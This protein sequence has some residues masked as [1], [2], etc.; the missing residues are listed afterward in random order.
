MA[1]AKAEL[2][3]AQM[4]QRRAAARAKAVRSPR[5]EW[6]TIRIELPVWESARAEAA[7]AGVS[8]AEW[9]GRKLGGRS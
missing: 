3:A 5:R 6:R 1:K 9:A 4:A 8:L 2:S 7:A